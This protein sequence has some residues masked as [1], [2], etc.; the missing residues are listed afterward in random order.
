MSSIRHDTGR[1]VTIEWTMDTR[2]STYTSHTIA[3]DSILNHQVAAHG[4][5]YNGSQI[6]QETKS[7]IYW[8]FQIHQVAIVGRHSNVTTSKGQVNVTFLGG[9]STSRTQEF[10][11]HSGQVLKK[12]FF[13]SNPQ[14]GELEIFKPYSA[15]NS[16]DENV[17]RLDAINVEWTLRLTG[18]FIPIE[19]PT[20]VLDTSGGATGA[21]GTIVG[22]LRRLGLDLIQSS[23]AAAVAFLT[24]ALLNAIPFQIQDCPTHSYSDKCGF[25]RVANVA[26][27]PPFGSFEDL[28]LTSPLM[29]PA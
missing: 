28:S 27:V 13:K 4:Y 8:G 5:R 15:A 16:T 3:K 9:R 1:P 22:T 20:G 29:Q 2:T 18:T 14:W 6:Q 17:L 12:Q 26:S 10:V 24:K 21:A 19:F 7:S 11:V 23:G 25:A